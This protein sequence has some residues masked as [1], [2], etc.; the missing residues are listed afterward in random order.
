MMR[1]VISI[2]IYI[3][4]SSGEKVA[5]FASY[6]GDGGTYEFGLVPG[7]DYFLLVRSSDDTNSNGGD[8]TF[9]IT[10]T[11]KNWELEYN[12]SFEAANSISSNK[13]YFGVVNDEYD[14]DFDIYLYDQ[15]MNRIQVFSI[16]D[17]QNKDF[18]LNVNKDKTYYL[19]IQAH[20]YNGG[21][22]KITLN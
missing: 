15:D 16:T 7:Q 8:Y 22:Y 21:N 3:I 18:S 14:D 12:S 19:L 17:V 1:Q 2:Y 4:N 5:G 9:D 11:E 20:S 6:D 10:F 13:E